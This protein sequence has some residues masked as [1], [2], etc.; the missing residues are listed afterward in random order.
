MLKH[1]INTFFLFFALL[2]LA[3]LSFWVVVPFWVFVLPVLLW[4]IIAVAGSSVITLNYHIKAYCGNPDVTANTI[5]LTF[6]DG[7]TP[8]TLKVLQLLKKYNAAATFFC[9]GTQVEKHPEILKKI[10]EEGHTVG[11]HT[12]SHAAKMGFFSAEKVKQE[13]QHANKAIY[14][15]ISKQALLFRPPFGVTNP[16]IAKALKATGHTV[17]GWNNR[18]LDAVIPDEDTIFNRVTQ[19]LAPGCIILLHDTSQK[20]VNVLERLL[21]FLQQNN[22]KSVTVDQLLNI[23]AYE[24]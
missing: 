21:V 24:E 20:T 13:L 23:P 4:L 5:S 15:A 18:S 9:I 8:E 7:P 16:N 19:R 10:I 2:L 14:N 1:R 17:I 12:Y 6:D 11:N 22:Y 3:G